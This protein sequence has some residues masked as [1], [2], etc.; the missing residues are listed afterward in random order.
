LSSL[1][2]VI[3]VFT[4]DQLV[5]QC[6]EFAQSVAKHSIQFLVL[7]FVVFNSVLHNPYRQ[8]TIGL[9]EFI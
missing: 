8:V 3:G 7:F 1:D 6:Y 9:H 4:N 2:L 5:D